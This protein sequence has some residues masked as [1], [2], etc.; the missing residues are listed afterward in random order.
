MKLVVLIPVYNEA[1]TLEAAV[2][3]VL[4]APP[5]KHADGSD[6][7]RVLL[8]VDDGSTDGSGPIVDALA[9][10]R[11]QIITARHPSN[12]GKGAAVATGLAA[13]LDAGAD[14]VLIHDADMEYDPADHADAVAPI[15]AGDAD[16]VIGSRYAG[17]SRRVTRFWHRLANRSLT[18]LSNA[19]SGLDLTDMEC[20][21]KVFTRE[22]AAKLEITEPRFAVEPQ[23][24][25]QLARMRVGEANERARVWEVPVSYAYRSHA[26]GKKITW[27]D[28][29]SAV[30]AIVKHN[31]G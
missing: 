25:A 31:L 12:R 3:R 4:H 20:C 2:Q 27:R 6:I 9:E 8:L 17:A 28:G 1:A 13:A 30:R 23:L 19:L 16:A 10:T 15:I 18:L 11:E 22:V 24:I 29:V 26:E 7:D 5:P 21:T 14:L